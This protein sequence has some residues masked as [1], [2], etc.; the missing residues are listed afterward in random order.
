M[1]IYYIVVVM[2][3]IFDEGKGC[4][5]LNITYHDMKS[6]NTNRYQTRTVN[7]KLRSSK[8]YPITYLSSG[9]CSGILRDYQVSKS[10]KILHISNGYLKLTSATPGL[11][12]PG[13]LRFKS[14]ITGIFVTDMYRIVGDMTR[15]SS[16]EKSVIY[17]M[18]L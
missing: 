6:I 4:S 16:K 10:T 3:G 12:N 9:R 14:N 8:R 13:K 18:A 11:S 7:I 1:V 17:Q 2:N 5:L 15:F